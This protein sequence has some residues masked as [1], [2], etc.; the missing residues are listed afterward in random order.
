MCVLVA[1]VAAPHGVAVGESLAATAAQ[2]SFAIEA[3]LALDRS[4][5]RLIPQGLRNEGFEYPSMGT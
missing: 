5:R 2:D 1:S 3:S 4:T